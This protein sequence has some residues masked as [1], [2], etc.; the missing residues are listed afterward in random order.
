MKVFVTGATG[1]TGSRV[2]PL[3]LQNGFEVRC[4]YRPSSD[5]SAL[6]GLNVEWVMGDVSDSE[7]LTSAMQGVDV[8][9]NI[10]SLGFGHA[11]SIVRAAKGAG[12]ASTIHRA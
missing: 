5:R 10:A 3:L 12:G 8:L 1:F 9:V 2:V 11:E 4:L 7:S 6:D